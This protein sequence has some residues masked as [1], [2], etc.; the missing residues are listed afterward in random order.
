M[1]RFFIDKTP[2]V[3]ETVSITGNQQHHISRV[4]RLGKDD[5]ITL[6]D[7][8]PFEYKAR[9]KRADKLSVALEIID[10]YPCNTEPKHRVTLFQALPKA[11]KMDSIIQKC[12]EL[13]VSSIVPIKTE[14]CVPRPASE[15]EQKNIRLLRIAHEAEKQSRRCIVPEILPLR[16]LGECVFSDY[17]LTL[18]AYEEEKEKT[19]KS[20]LCNSSAME[21]AI[22]IGPEGGFTSEE[23]AHICA[24][25]AK[26]VTLGPRILRTETAGA[27]ML[28]M[29]LYEL[30][31]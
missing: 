7:G 15:Y 12:V 6:C 9:I 10:C 1:H 30:E 13:G 20:V 19:L 28:A 16:N 31:V 21:I 5:I 8:Q 4:L 14:R 11:G 3:G 25:G 2:V 29:V 24:L 18:L 27:A 26:S 22:V 23:A 17:E